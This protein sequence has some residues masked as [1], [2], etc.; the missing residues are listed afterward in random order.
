MLR[1]PPTRLELKMDDIQEFDQLRREIESKKRAGTAAAFFAE[2]EAT[3]KNPNG[4]NGAGVGAPEKSRTEA[5][6]ERIGF[7]PQTRRNT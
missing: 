1:R 5:I 3:P 7:N 4:V 2:G 6:H